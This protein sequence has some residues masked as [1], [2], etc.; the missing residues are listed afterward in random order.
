M[1]D[2][3]ANRAGKDPPKKAGWWDQRS[4]LVQVGMSVGV[5]IGLL[6]G[7]LLGLWLG[8]L[9]DGGMGPAVAA[10]T[11]QAGIG[12]GAVAVATVGLRRQRSTEE[13]LKTEKKRIKNEQKKDREKADLDRGNAERE[14]VRGLRDRF[15]TAAGQLGDESAAIR[16]AG[17]YAMSALADDWLT[18][19]EPA[20][21]E[22]QVCVDVLCAYLRTPR[23]H[24][25]R[26]EVEPYD[27]ESPTS[28]SKHMKALFGPGP[29]E[30][31]SAMGVL[32]GQ[33]SEIGP[34]Y[35]VK[36]H[37]SSSETDYLFG[38]GLDFLLL[39]P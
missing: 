3:K 5:F 17:V 7:T 35:V 33:R 30:V 2:K 31:M 13:A 16:L 25:M 6:V 34:C 11:V 23:D 18:Q 28:I 1:T 9:L 10:V 19:D 24:G 21:A 15:T 39:R 37:Q 27:G 26:K 22:A 12:V 29:T 20:E 14:R 8:G 4:L 32:P 38:E 36:N